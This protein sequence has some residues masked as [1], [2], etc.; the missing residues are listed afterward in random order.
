MMIIDLTEIDNSPRPLDVSVPAAE[1]DLEDSDLRLTGDVRIKGEI[2]KRSAQ[3]DLTGTV[4]ASAEV[5]CTRCLEPVPQDLTFEFAASFVAP[6]HFAADKEREVAADDL[7]VDV[8]ESD[9]IDLR[10]VAREQILLNLP[11]QV[12]CKADCKGLCEKCGANRNLID[13]KCGSNETD[14]RWAALKNLR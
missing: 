6:E 10:E 11:G 5:D 3:V 4:S 1:I 13:C 12:F 7:D 8:L 9:R 14:P 2:F